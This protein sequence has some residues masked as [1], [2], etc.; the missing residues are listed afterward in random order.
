[1]KRLLQWLRATPP[2]AID[3][4]R[5]ALATLTPAE[6]ETVRQWA[7]DYFGPPVTTDTRQ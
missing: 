7:G 3:A 1:M 4:R 6:R 5:I 2:A